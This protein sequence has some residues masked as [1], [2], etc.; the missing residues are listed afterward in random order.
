MVEI[1]RYEITG[2]AIAGGSAYRLSRWIHRWKTRWLAGEPIAVL[3]APDYSHLIAIHDENA[4]RPGVLTRPVQLELDL[5]YD[6]DDEEL[7]A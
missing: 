4:R 7:D 2:T 5:G 6:L 1:G 3:V